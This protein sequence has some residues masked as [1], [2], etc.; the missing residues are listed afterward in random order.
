LASKGLEGSELHV[1]DESSSRTLRGSDLILEIAFC[2]LNVRT[3]YEG[4]CF[5]DLSISFPEEF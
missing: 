1:D 4:N 5:E 2:K 3:G